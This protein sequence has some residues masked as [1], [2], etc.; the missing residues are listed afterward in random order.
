MIRRLAPDEA[1]ERAHNAY[2]KATYSPVPRIDVLRE[3]RNARWEAEKAERE[4]AEK[5]QQVERAHV[6][7][8]RNM[9]IVRRE[10]A[11]FYAERFPQQMTLFSFLL[12]ETA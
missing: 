9:E 8:T 2:R 5:A 1:L 7:E 6:V 10:S 3:I 11:A 12:G 4:Q